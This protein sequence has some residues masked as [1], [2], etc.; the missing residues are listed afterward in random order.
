MLR[1][2]FVC[3]S[4]CG[5]CA[6]CARAHGTQHPESVL[7]CQSV[8]LARQIASAIASHEPLG[9][10][11]HATTRFA[12]KIL[13]ELLPRL[14]AA[15]VTSLRNSSESLRDMHWMSM[16]EDF[17]N[18]Q[19]DLVSSDTSFNEF[20]SAA[21]EQL[22]QDKCE[23][24]LTLRGLLGCSVLEHCLTKRHRVNYGTTDRCV[25]FLCI[26]QVSL[27]YNQKEY[28]DHPGRK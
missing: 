6:V 9:P 24:M 10:Q 19:K 5:Y 22:T 4:P 18:L 3:P 16:I 2:A 20:K 26:V 17:S 1:A 7:E 21:F 28:T 25:I 23:Q 11:S 14:K 13:E 12:G 8:S 27:H 15:I